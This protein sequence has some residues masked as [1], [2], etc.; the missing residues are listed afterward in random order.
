[1]FKKEKNKK[2][3][4]NIGFIIF[5]FSGSALMQVVEVYKE[6]QSQQMNIVSFFFYLTLYDLIFIYRKCAR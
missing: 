3:G 1:M 6:I 4:F 5:L 2:I